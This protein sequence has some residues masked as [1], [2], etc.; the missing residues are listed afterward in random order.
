MQ[1]ILASTS[2]YRQQLLARLA[3]S[4][5]TEAPEVD[6]TPR[7]DEPA[8]ELVTRLALAKARAVAKRYPQAVVIGSDQVAELDGRLLGKPGNRA[9]ALDQLTASSERCVCFFTAVAVCRHAS[10]HERVHLEPVRVH[11]RALS[12]AETLRYLE[13][14]QP[15]DCAGSFKV[16]GL[17]ISLFQS[18]E[19]ADP[20]SLEGLPLIALSAM[21]R[22]LKLQVP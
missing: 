15:Y 3:V 2:P 1:I 8:D 9:A 20:T 19:S 5:K 16:E 21:L 7:P 4:F 12:R 14:E 11:F 17:G 18:V 13:L 10:G 6:E 22:E